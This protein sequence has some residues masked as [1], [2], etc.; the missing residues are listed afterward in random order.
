MKKI[1]VFALL[2]G[3]I[4]LSGCTSKSAKIVT[5]VDGAASATL[6]DIVSSHGDAKSC[7]SVI[8]GNVYDLTSFITKHPG[9]A[10]AILASCGKDATAAFDMKHGMDPKKWE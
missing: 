6:V 3:V 4:I 7:W 10:D 8:S 9:G 1:W 5:P 2:F